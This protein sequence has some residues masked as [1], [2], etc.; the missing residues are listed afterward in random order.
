MAGGGCS[1]INRSWALRSFAGYMSQRA[2]GNVI[3]LFVLGNKID[4]LAK[5]RATPVTQR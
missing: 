4:E 3:G 5:R 2:V 1:C